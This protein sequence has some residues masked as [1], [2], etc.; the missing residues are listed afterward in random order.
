VCV[1]SVRLPEARDRVG[2]VP[3]AV[4][5]HEA[6][7]QIPDFLEGHLDEAMAEGV[8]WKFAPLRYF[9]D[10]YE[11]SLDNDCILWSLPAALR[12]W[13]HEE[14]TAQCLVAEDVAPAFGQFSRLCG[15]APRNGGIRGL[16]PIHLYDHADAMRAVLANYPVTLKSELDEQGLQTAAILRHGPPLVVTVKEVSICSPWPPH[17][18]ELGSCGAHFC[19]LNA[20]R[21]SWEWEGRNA[22]ELT[23]EHW[24]AVK[25]FIES[26]IMSGQVSLR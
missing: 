19:G 6:T 2:E 20:R 14:G 4:E 21:L 24:D 15:T 7:A 9:P 18:R 25:G 8:A 13:W 17:V 1:N 11:L 3:T 12:E 10:L 16:P 5:W 23:Y 22:V 26:K